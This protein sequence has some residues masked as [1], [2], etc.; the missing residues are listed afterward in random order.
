M[1]R[2]LPHPRVEVKEWDPDGYPAA[3]IVQMGDRECTMMEFVRKV[4]Q[5]KPH[6]VLSERLTELIR[7]SNYGYRGKHE[8][9]A[10]ATA[11]ATDR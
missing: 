2:Y 9:E 6:V 8:K 5:P 4:E 7:G 11:I 1:T 10:G 3:V